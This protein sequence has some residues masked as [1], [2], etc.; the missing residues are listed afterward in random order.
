MENGIVSASGNDKSLIPF[1]YGRVTHTYFTELAQR[2]MC[3]F[4]GTLRR[5]LN[6][7]EEK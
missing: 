4:R 2:C 1:L 5:L 3:S 6:F 7:S